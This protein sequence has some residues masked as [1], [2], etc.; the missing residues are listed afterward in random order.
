MPMKI[1]ELSQASQVPVPTI[2]FYI[3]EGLLPPGR[4]T[5]R[6]QADYTESHVERLALIRALREAAALP[7]ETI[8]NVLR[9]AD[10]AKEDFIIAAIDAL[11]RPRQVAVE[12]SPVLQR[13]AEQAL[14]AL[15]KRRKWQ[16]KP[17]DVSLRDAARA[18]AVAK[19]SFTPESEERALD[20]YADAADRL[21]Q[22]EI[23]TDWA[24]ADSPNAAL[25]YAVVGTVLFEP[26][27]LALRRM[28]HVARTRELSQGKTR[29]ATAEPGRGKRR[30]PRG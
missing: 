24:P 22:Y 15:A 11:E 16:I 23:P 30:A 26:F 8:A 5:A 29:A 10:N 3:R 25:R 12:V 4:R 6:N 28:A 27:I 7:I 1:S 13:A 21:A 19:L 14:L 20:V 18:I 17:E 2:K 9:A